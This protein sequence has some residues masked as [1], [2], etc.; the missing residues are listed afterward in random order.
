MC[1]AVEALSADWWP[2]VVTSGLNRGAVAVNWLYVLVTTRRR[3]SGRS[4]GCSRQSIE[5]SEQDLHGVC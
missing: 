2:E 5:N 3:F 4:T 1:S